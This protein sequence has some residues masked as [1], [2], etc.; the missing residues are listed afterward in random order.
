MVRKEVPLSLVAAAN[1]TENVVTDY[2]ALQ[3]I[4]LS[5]EQQA[6]GRALAAADA[7]VAAA[8]QGLRGCR[9]VQLCSCGV[10]L[11]P[12]LACSCAGLPG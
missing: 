11:W 9:S 2:V 10:E 4:L 7:W 8:C 1:P 5:E 6:H 3:R 12:V